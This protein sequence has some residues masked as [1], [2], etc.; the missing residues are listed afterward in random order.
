MTRC[1]ED[2]E[3]KIK[4]VPLLGTA[5]E[6]YKKG[7]MYRELFCSKKHFNFCKYAF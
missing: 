1:P 6:K 5:L 2:P 7:T 3:E 4:A